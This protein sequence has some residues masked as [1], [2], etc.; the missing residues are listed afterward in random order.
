M[1]PTLESIS[2]TRQSFCLSGIVGRP[3]PIPFKPS[4]LHFFVQLSLS[5]AEIANAITENLGLAGRTSN[6]HLLQQERLLP[7]IKWNGS[8]HGRFVSGL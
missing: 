1:L 2:N 8:S 6:A 4:C 7:L 3:P 5:A